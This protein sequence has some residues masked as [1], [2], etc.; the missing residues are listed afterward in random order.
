MEEDTNKLRQMVD[1]LV[2]NPNTALCI[3]N[4]RSDANELMDKMRF[5]PTRIEIESLNKNDIEFDLIGLKKQMQEIEDSVY[6]ENETIQAEKTIPQKEARMRLILLNHQEYSRLET[7]Y[8][9]FKRQKAD[10]EANINK[11]DAT[12][13]VYKKF[14]N[15]QLAVISRQKEL[16]E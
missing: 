12:L 16:D 4:D 2:S 7:K 8:N 3:V 5:I 15:W 11:L 6:L 1:R 13:G 14:F 9:Q 10:I